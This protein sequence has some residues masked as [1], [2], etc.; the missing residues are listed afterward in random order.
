MNFTRLFKTLRGTER[1][2]IGDN[3]HGTGGCALMTRHDEDLRDFA[4]RQGRLLRSGL[5]TPC[6]PQTTLK[7]IEL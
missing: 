1:R 3:D 5:L 2:R 6:C 4:L 7:L